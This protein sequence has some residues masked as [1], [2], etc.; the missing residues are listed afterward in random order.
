MVS[1][2]SAKSKLTRCK[3]TALFHL[4]SET[5][6]ILQILQTADY[7]LLAMSEVHKSHSAFDWSVLQ[8]VW[9][10]V[11]HNDRRIAMKLGTHN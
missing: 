4:C 8:S 9:S 10:E 2:N 11:L 7:T 1:N 6:T 3:D 5:S